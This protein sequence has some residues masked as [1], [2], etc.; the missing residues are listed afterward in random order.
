MVKRKIAALLLL[1]SFLANEPLALAKTSEATLLSSLRDVVISQ[2]NDRLPDPT[3][4]AHLKSQ[5]QTAFEQELEFLKDSSVSLSEVKK[6]VIGH[7]SQAGRTKKIEFA[8]VID[9]LSI[10]ELNALTKT[11]PSEKRMALL[12]ATDLKSQ[13]NLFKRYTEE[14]INA[15]LRSEVSWVQ[16]H[17]KEALINRLIK[18]E[19]LLHTKGRWHALVPYLLG[20]LILATLVVVYMASCIDDEELFTL[21]FRRCPRDRTSCYYEDCTTYLRMN[22]CSHVAVKLFDEC[23]TSEID[24]IIVY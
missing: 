3:L 7:L 16:N 19:A 21:T 15:E 2:Q 5:Y 23:K 24:P 1:F 13:K 17:D 6:R 10:T 20:I 18:E 8:K 12:L 4:E 14:E 11:L 9:D 22:N